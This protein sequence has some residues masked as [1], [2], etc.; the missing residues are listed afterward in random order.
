[1]NK[2]GTGVILIGILAIAALGLSGYLFAQG[3]FL[4]PTTEKGSILVGYWEDLVKNKDNPDHDDDWDWLVALGDHQYNNS[5]YIL[6]NNQK[7]RFTLTRAG[8]YKLTLI[9]Y[10]DLLNNDYYYSVEF[11]KNSVLLNYIVRLYFY[12]SSTKYDHFISCSLTFYSDGND[13]FEI[14]AKCSTTDN[15]ILGY[16]MAYDML[17]IEYFL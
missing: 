11:L 1:M 16:D 6:V 9:T 14:N 2:T 4:S 12:S 15:F 10:L 13:Y 3:V 5:N 17:S 8:Y 7:N